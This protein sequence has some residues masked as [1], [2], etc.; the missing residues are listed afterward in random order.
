MST[1]KSADISW[2]RNPNL[3]NPKTK[4]I[5]PCSLLE[6]QVGGLKRL[7]ELLSSPQAASF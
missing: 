7:D 1:S 4:T 3:V 5:R 6:S 2:Y